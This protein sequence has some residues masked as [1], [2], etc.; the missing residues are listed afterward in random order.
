MNCRICGKQDAR[1][2]LCELKTA[3]IAR[4]AHIDCNGHSE[5]RPVTVAEVDAAIGEHV[6]HN[7]PICVKTGTGSGI[8]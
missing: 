3:R 2:R 8:G 4:R 5:Y 1:I 7:S 6:R